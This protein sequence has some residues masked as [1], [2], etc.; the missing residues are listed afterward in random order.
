MPAHSSSARSCCRRPRPPLSAY[1]PIADAPV[2]TAASYANEAPTFGSSLTVIPRLQRYRLYSAT[3]PRSVS[4]PARKR[5][6]MAATTRPA[7]EFDKAIEI[8]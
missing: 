6:R 7:V 3:E 2:L 5:F 1:Q 8:C 4:R